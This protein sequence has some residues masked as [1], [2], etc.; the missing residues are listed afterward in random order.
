MVLRRFAWPYG[1]QRASFCGSFTGWRECPMGL[2]GAEFQVVFD[3]PPGV[4]QYRFL[5]D[6]VWRCDET[7]PCVRDEYGLISN[8][9]L[10]DNTHPVV[11]P[12]TSIRVVSMDEGTILTTMPPDQLSQNSG[13]QIAIFRHR[14]SEILLHNTIYDVVPVSSKI[15]VLDARLPVKQAFKIMHDEGLSLVPLWDDQQQTVTGMLTA[16]DFVLILRKLQ[17]NIRT[18]G[19]E[20]LE[21][22]SV[23]AW[24]EAKLQFYGGPDVAAIQRRP[25]IHVKDSDNLR[26]V[27]LAIIRNE[28]SS[29]PI[30]KPS[31]DSSGMPLLGLATLPGIV[32]FICSKLQE[33]PEGYSFLQ[34][35]I[36]SM[37]IGT[38]SPHTGKASNRQLRTSRPSTP[39]NSCLDLLLE[40]RVSSIPIVDDNGALLDVYSL[41]DIM[42]LGKNDVYTRIELEQVTVEHALELQYQVNGRRHCHT[43]LSTSTFLEVLEQL[44]APGVRRV[45]VIEPRSR[46]VQ[47][48]I[49]L[50]DAFTFLI[51]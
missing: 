38:W 7:K 29:V 35:Q 40:D 13:V 47:G 27:A 44:S 32:K 45:V 28:I 17:R 23:S 30:F 11:Q 50:R 49:S 43:C 10:V 48:I 39:L 9:V 20:E 16:S 34:N 3:L 46:F 31:T 21:M 42:A 18:L 14:V 8:E 41:S 2:V 5:V 15:A 24:K 19:H 25:L 33:Q 4:Y 26:D 22:H 37:P 1:G 6:G 12:E 51:G 36:V